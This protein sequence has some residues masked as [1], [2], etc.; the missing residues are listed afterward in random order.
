MKE[1]IFET[2]NLVYSYSTKQAK[3]SLDNVSVEIQRC[4]LTF[5]QPK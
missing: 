5:C 4:S 1:C 2:E 3:P